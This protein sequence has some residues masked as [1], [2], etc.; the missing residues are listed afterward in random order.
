M[1]KLSDVSAVIVTRGDHP[2]AIGEILDSLPY[3]DVVIWDNSKREKDE[4]C[5]GRYL[6]M[7]FTRNELIYLQDDD[8]L[9]TAHEQLLE[10]HQPGRI[11]A[12]MP[13]P[14]YERTGYDREES[15]Q[16]GA[17]S[18]M[19]RSMPSKAFAQYLSLWPEDDLFLT[20]CDDICGILLPSLRVDLGYTILPHAD[21]P[22]RICTTEGCWERRATVAGRALALRV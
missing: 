1:A 15:V 9:F 17:G 14:W 10:A 6:G 22:G 19:E 20:Y 18:L 12:N 8:I 5:L 11:T 16:V 7:I 21:D 2:E 13:S 4:K 3:E